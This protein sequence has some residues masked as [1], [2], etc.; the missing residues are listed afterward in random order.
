MVFHFR[1]FSFLSAQN[2]RETT[3]VDVFHTANSRFVDASRMNQTVA[4]NL[5][6]SPTLRNFTLS[7]LK[8]A[9]KEFHA[10]NK[11]GEG[12]FAIV[13]KG[14]VKSLQHR[15]FLIEVAVKQIKQGQLGYRTWL[16]E[17]NV[18][19]I[20][21]D[22][23]VKLIGFCNEDSQLLLVY[24]YMP[25][26]SLDG[27]LAANSN[28]PLSWGRRLNIAK[29][30]ATGLEHLH[31]AKI[32][33]RDFKPSNI[34]LD[35]NWN[36]KLCDFGF[37]RDGPQDGRTHVSTM[38]VGTKG[39]AAPEYVQ[40]GRLTSMVDVWSYGIFLEELI[41]GAEKSK[42]IVDPRL[43]GYSERSMQKVTLI[44]KK[45]LEKDPKM[46]PTM[47]E[48]LEMVTDAIASENQQVG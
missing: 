41:T 11:I 7:E 24:E 42:L 32:I 40:T 3:T 18:G 14:T 35:N 48:V 33:F 15:S 10:S 39:Y 22:N 21:H 30:A 36:A 12:G 27:H 28:T 19:E 31:K 6:I 9:T 46:R 38:V 45:C 37:A 23:L 4:P 2:A 47:R 16:T 43:Q 17:V 26:K 1:C 29:D 20:N 34:L 25:K 8:T 44:A 5:N 13:Y